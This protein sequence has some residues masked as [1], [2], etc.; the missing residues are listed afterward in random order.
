MKANLNQT[1]PVN[2][3]LGYSQ[4]GL[5]VC[6]GNQIMIFKQYL[7]LEALGRIVFISCIPM[8]LGYLDNCDE[9]ENSW[10]ELETT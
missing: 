2:S 1:P 7:A 5:T 4:E 3:L 10:K 6:V 8:E 9:A